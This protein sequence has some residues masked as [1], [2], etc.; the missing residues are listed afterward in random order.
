MLWQQQPPCYCCDWSS[1]CWGEENTSQRQQCWL[2]PFNQI[3]SK[4]KEKVKR[5]FLSTKVTQNA[6]CTTPSFFWASTCCHLRLLLSKRI[7]RKQKIISAPH[8]TKQEEDINDDFYN[9]NTKPFL[10]CYSDQTQKLRVLVLLFMPTQ[11]FRPWLVSAS[12][13]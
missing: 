12:L 8:F 10:I 7:V 4:N 11:Q 13:S 1:T 9:N 2:G 6:A 5:M 3:N